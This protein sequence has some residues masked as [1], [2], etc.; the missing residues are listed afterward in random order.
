[1]TLNEVNIIK[2][3]VLDATEA[4]V[5]AR[6]SVADFAKTQIGV[7]EGIPRKASGKYYHTVRCNAISGVA[8]SGIVYHNVLSIGNTEFPN[9]SVVF[10][11]APNAQFSNQFILGKLDNTPIHITAGSISI[12]GTESRPNFSVSSEGVVRI[13]KG[14]ITLGGSE[15]AP[16]FRVDNDGNVYIKKGEINI[17]EHTI[18]NIT[19]YDV[20]LNKNGI[21]LG[22]LGT[23]DNVDQYNFSVTDRG[24]VTIK[25]GSIN[26]TYNSTVQDYNF[27]VNS[28]GINLGVTGT[29]SSDKSYNFSVNSNGKV[30]IK[31]GSI[32]LGLTE[33]AHLTT[34]KYTFVADENGNLSVGAYE[35]QN[36]N[37]QA[38]SWQYH[39]KLTKDGDLT[40]GT[41]FKLDRNGNL[42]SGGTS[43]SN[44]TFYVT[45]EGNMYVGGTN[46]SA[47]FYITN[48]ANG[49]STVRIKQGEITLGGSTSSPA[50]RVTNEGNVYIKKGEIT[51]GT[52][53]PTSSK[54]FAA[55]HVSTEGTLTMRK[56]AIRMDYR[57][58]I[59]GTGG[60]DRYNVNLSSGGL[61]LG[62]LG[63]EGSGTS[64]NPYEPQ[65]NFT[66]K[67]NGIITIKRGSINLGETT[68]S[69]STTYKFMVDD[70]GN[71]TARS[72]K[73]AA[74]TISNT[75]LSVGDAMLA[76]NRMGCGYAGHG[77]ANLVGGTSGTQYDPY[78]ALSNSGTFSQCLDGI[79]IYGCKGT[80]SNITRGV[81]EI[82]NVVNNQPHLMMTRYLSNIP[83]KEIYEDAAGYL[84][85][86]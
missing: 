50:F 44:A 49:K 10:L 59:E 14:E 22:Y 53:S 76:Q 54:T 37:T 35:Y 24:V 47:N 5:D 51:I 58:T 48:D 16:N 56:G 6:L 46:T 34:K 61:R 55:F 84:H 27:K 75:T 8:D 63:E 12:G 79:R 86:R 82:Y 33:P 18:N 9:G 19:R 85:W 81:V 67:E 77:I 80:G 73:I 43:T 40:A 4:Y 65:Y 57:T 41:K 15:S 78:L 39:F 2:N 68:I 66:L 72:G 71:L 21:N 64:S 52:V 74:F 28:S 36:P 20:N 62:Y 1:M 7:T 32:N 23:T 60:G 83:E 45:N 3:S 29:N 38:W 25:S 69:G 30:T 11:I 31:S 13:R 42:F 70:N 26:L 17:G